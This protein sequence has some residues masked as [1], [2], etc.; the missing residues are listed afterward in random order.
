MFK[1]LKELFFG[2]APQREEQPVAP[3]KIEVAEQPKVEPTPEPVAGVPAV[4]VKTTKPKK[5]VKPK[6]AADPKPATK[7]AAAKAVP[8]KAAPKKAEP[9]T[10]IK[11]AKTS[12]TKKVTP[13]M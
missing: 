4:P 10:A 13:L 6:K 7:P 3:Y 11:P 1:A 9:K 12:R 5:E 2:K 8:K